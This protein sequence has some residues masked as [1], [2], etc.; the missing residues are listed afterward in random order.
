MAFCTQHVVPGIDFTDDPLLQGRNFSYLDTQLTRLGG[1]NFMEIRTLSSSFSS[2]FS[3]ALFCSF[4]FSSLSALLFFHFRTIT[5]QQLHSDQPA[6]V[7]G[8]EQPARRLHAAAHQQGPRQLPP[9]S[10]RLSRSR[11]R[12]TGSSVCAFV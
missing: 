6:D 5:D 10:H 2:A 7:P 3:L 4:S 11:H 1:P 8:D 12:R 9:Q